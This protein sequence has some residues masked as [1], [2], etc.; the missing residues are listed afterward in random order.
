MQKLFRILSS[1]IKNYDDTWHCL[2]NSI[3]TYITSS[4]S[5]L[6]PTLLF[7]FFFF[8]SQLQKWSAASLHYVNMGEK[9]Q[10]KNKKTCEKVLSLDG[11]PVMWFEDPVP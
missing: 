10:N 6:N 5:G 4:F 1:F 7:F 2:G 8:P 9:N 3:T 11:F